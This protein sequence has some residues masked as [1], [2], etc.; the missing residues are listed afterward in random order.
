MIRGITG[1]DR[2]FRE[3]V[4]GHLEL[5]SNLEDH[6]HVIRTL[7][8][9]DPGIDLGRVGVT[10]FSGGGFLA[11]HAALRHGDLYKVAAACSGNYDQ[12]VFWKTWGERYLGRYDPETYA[13]QAARTY[14]SGL[15]GKLLL[16]HG[17]MDKG[18]H[19]AG[20]FQLLDALIRADKDPDVLVL[21]AAAHEVNDYAW[22][23]IMKYFDA[24]L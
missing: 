6:V 10:G 20:M 19:P 5:T 7:A 24:H 12:A 15:T 23:R 2:D 4:V 3:S 21:P 18:V 22:R 13:A 17:M 11:A 9:S 1:R 16:I 8:D 14:A